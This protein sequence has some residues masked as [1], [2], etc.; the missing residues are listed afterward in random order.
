VVQLP[1][2]VECT[3]RDLLAEDI[4]EVKAAL[5]NALTFLDRAATIISS[6]N[7]TSLR[8]FEKKA[9]TVRDLA[10]GL[11]RDLDHVFEA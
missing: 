9:L 1:D 3:H 11:R 10:A 2:W 8:A 7:K 5:S 4:V 6:S